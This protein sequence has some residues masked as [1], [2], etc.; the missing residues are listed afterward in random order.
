MSEEKVSID[1]EI[2]AAEQELRNSDTELQKEHAICPFSGATKQKS[3]ED[4]DTTEGALPYQY[5]PLRMGGRGG[6][7]MTSEGSMALIKNEVSLAD[8]KKMTGAFYQL[9]F[10]DETL[11]KFIRSHSDPHGDRFAKWIH[12]KLSGSNVWDKD[13]KHRDLT[14]VSVA[15]G[16]TAVVHDRSSAH[17]AA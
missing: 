10:Q 5:I 6:T 1:D 2:L 15:G 7:H 3:V 9:A 14:P 8:L 16:R 11:D 4:G 13:R 17:A 12:Q